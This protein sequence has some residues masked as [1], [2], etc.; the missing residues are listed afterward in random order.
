V[1]HLKCL[2]QRFQQKVFDALEPMMSYNVSV[3]KNLC[4]TQQEAQCVF[5][6]K[7]TFYFVKILQPTTNNGSVAVVNTAVDT[8]YVM[9]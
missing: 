4:T 3:V 2:A 6:N 7:G 8:T 1:K 5:K 9:A